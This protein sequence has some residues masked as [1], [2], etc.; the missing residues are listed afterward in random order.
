MC[1]TVFIYLSKTIV[2][3]LVF[4]AIIAHSDHKAVIINLLSAAIAVAGANQ[5]G[6]LAY[7]LKVGNIIGA[8]PEAQVRG[9]IIGS[10]FGSLISCGIYKLYASQYPIPGPLFKV[11]SAYLVLSTT[12]LLLGRGLPEGVLPFVI[13]AAILSALATVVKTKYE[14]EWWQ[15][16]IPSGV[17][18][19]M[20]ACFKTMDP[21]NL[22]I[23]N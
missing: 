1:V 21:Y 10:L 15:K 22:L 23:A 2:S 6:D 19:A 5:A 16:L 9:Q 11:P 8:H 17:S 4:A 13:T 18:F 12:R 7:D 3:Q 14:H 20:G